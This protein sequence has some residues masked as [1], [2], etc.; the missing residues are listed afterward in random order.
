MS[1]HHVYY[2]SYKNLPEVEAVAAFLSSMLTSRTWGKGR[3]DTNKGVGFV[4]M[5]S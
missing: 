2:H 4:K 1:R 5:W 3:C